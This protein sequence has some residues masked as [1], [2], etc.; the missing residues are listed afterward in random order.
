MPVSLFS[1][2]YFS[3]LVQVFSC[4]AFPFVWPFHPFF[5][6]LLEKTGLV[7]VSLFNIFNLFQPGPRPDF[8]LWGTVPPWDCLRGGMVSRAWLQLHTAGGR[9]SGMSGAPPNG[10]GGHAVNAVDVLE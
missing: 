8:L 3:N 6:A 9:V 10:I 7:P 1:I 2:L 4:F 5:F